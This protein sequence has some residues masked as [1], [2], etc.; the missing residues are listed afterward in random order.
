MFNINEM[1]L[2]EE[3][4]TVVSRY[5]L[6]FELPE[7]CKKVYDCEKEVLA[8]LGFYPEKRDGYFMKKYEGYIPRGW[9]GFAIGTPI[10]E[11]WMDCLDEA[12]TILTEADPEL[13]IHQIKLKF[14]G[15][16]FYVE[17]QKIEDIY[18]IGSLLEDSMYDPRL[19]Y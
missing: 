18:A 2:L 11:S 1:E 3:I 14:G 6:T 4:K 8:K 10:P 19:I 15:L 16:R 9:Y 17:S 7:G 5:D 13:E 12:L